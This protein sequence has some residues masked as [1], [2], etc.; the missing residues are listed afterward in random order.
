VGRLL[1]LLCAA[2]TFRHGSVGADGSVDGGP[3]ASVDATIATDAPSPAACLA[4]PH[5]TLCYSFDEPALP[6]MLPDEGTSTE[7]VAQLTTVILGGQVKTGQSWTGQNRPVV[8]GR[9]SCNS[10]SI[11]P[12]SLLVASCASSAVRT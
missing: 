6:A 11:S 1:L 3:D 9:R 8:P 10:G 4:D 7:A 2:C 12:A 5:L